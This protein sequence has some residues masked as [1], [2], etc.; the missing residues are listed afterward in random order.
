[1]P[2]FMERTAILPAAGII[3]LLLVVGAVSLPDRTAGLLAAA[4]A[5]AVRT[6]GEIA[7]AQVLARSTRRIDRNGDGVGEFGFLPDLLAGGAGGPPALGVPFEE[8]NRPGLFRAGG[9]IYHLL[10]PAAD[11]TALD[12]PQAAAVDPRLAEQVFLAFAWPERPGREGRRAYSVNQD[13]L[14]LENVASPPSAS[15]F[16]PLPKLWAVDPFTGQSMHPSLPPT[17]W[18]VLL[19]EAQRGWYR[20]RFTQAGLP[21]PASLATPDRHR[22]PD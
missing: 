9:F 16:Q 7:V 14:V 6:L 19:P 5:R 17:L 1:M 11:G 12:L 15:M 2:S 13:L 18:S 4:D 3:L 8:T 22:S 10:L 21:L 20:T